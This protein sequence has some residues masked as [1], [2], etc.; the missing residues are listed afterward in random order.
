MPRPDGKSYILL[1][2]EIKKR[3]ATFGNCDDT[4]ESTLVRLMDKAEE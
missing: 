4:Y 2:P 1:E 3:L